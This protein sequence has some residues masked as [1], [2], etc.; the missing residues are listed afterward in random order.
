[1]ITAERIAAGSYRVYGEHGYQLATIRKD[2]GLTYPW[3]FIT[4][5][6]GESGGSTPT[7]KAAV[8]RINEQQEE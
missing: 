4:Y 1:M 8:Q 6:G 2:G 7:L 5:V 3:W